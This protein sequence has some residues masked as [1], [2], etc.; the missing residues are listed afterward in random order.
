MRPLI[1][2]HAAAASVALLLGGHLLLRRRKGDLLHRRVGLVW[3]AAM[4]FTVVSSFW[5]R[6]LH[7]GSF[8][9]IH[10]LSLFTFCTLS[11]GVWAALT[12]RARLHRSFVT[13]SY[14][15]LVGAFFGAV[16]VPQREIPQLLVSSPVTFAGALLGCLLFA[17]TV[18]RVAA[19]RPGT[20]RNVPA[21]PTRARPS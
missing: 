21:P 2:T 6:E 16:A 5:I 19:L 9:W 14:L 12:G 4:Y 3:V 13:G 10:G 18:V 11:V 1:A 8:S 17:V 15:G 20:V 7:P